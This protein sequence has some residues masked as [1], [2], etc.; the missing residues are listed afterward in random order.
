M[1]PSGE[2]GREG[3]AEEEGERGGIGMVGRRGGGG[4]RILLAA[5]EAEAGKRRGD[6]AAAD[7]AR[8]SRGW[9]DGGSRRSPSVRARVDFAGW[10]EGLFRGCLA[11]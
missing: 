11:V 10:V 6:P 8:E 3:A 9:V 7:A 2:G 5:A 4:T 1:G